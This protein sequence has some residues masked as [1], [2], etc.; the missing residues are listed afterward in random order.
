MNPATPHRPPDQASVCQAAQQGP[1]P[2]PGNARLRRTG[3]DIQPERATGAEPNF[4]NTENHSRI[5]LE[6][7]SRATRTG[8]NPGNDRDCTHDL[9][10]LDL[11]TTRAGDESRQRPNWDDLPGGG[12]ARATRAGTNPGNATSGSPTRCMWWTTRNEGR[13]KPGNAQFSRYLEQDA[14]LRSTRAGRTPGNAFLLRHYPLADHD[15]RATRT[16]AEP[17]DA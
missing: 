3:A 15:V 12:A 6:R 1:E 16:G 11:R 7:N 8:P 5:K 13:A 17:G 14:V 9:D 2:N 10:V 4:G